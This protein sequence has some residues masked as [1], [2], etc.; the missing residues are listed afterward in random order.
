MYAD[1]V[2][3]FLG[4][5]DELKLL[6]GISFG[7]ADVTAPANSFPMGRVPLEHSVVLHDTPESSR[8]SSSSPGTARFTSA[9]AHGNPVEAQGRSRIGSSVFRRCPGGF[10]TLRWSGACT[11]R[12]GRG[13]PGDVRDVW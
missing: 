11:A 1:T 9:A 6:F 4:V 7:T 3:G 12:A 5:P 13:H 2:R 8:S 10:G